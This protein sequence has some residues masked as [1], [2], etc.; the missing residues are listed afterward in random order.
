MGI[1][2]V[3]TP[4]SCIRD[5]VIQVTLVQ[6]GPCRYLGE[7]CSWTGDTASEE[8]A[9]MSH[10]QEMSS[11]A[12]LARGRAVEM[13]GELKGS[14][15]RESAGKDQ[16]G[17]GWLNKGLDIY[18]EWE[19]QWKSCRGW[20]QLLSEEMISSRGGSK[21]TNFWGCCKDLGQGSVNLFLKELASKCFWR[22]RPYGLRGNYSTLWLYCES[23]QGQYVNKWAWPDLFLPLSWL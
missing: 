12:E 8:E 4:E 18:P 20:C 1:T 23:S 11:E 14:Q 17:P 2:A 6:T 10:F 9:C 16:A 15:W 22:W 3:S 13:V 5:S 19:G 21:E 7:E